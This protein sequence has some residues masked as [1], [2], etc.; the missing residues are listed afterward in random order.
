MTA[1]FLEAHSFRNERKNLIFHGGQEEAAVWYLTV[2]WML[3]PRVIHLTQRVFCKRRSCLKH[4]RIPNAKK[5]ISSQVKADVSGIDG[6]GG[7]CR[8]HLSMIMCPENGVFKG[9]AYHSLT[10]YDWL[11]LMRVRILTTSASLNQL[12]MKHRSLIAR[13]CV[14]VR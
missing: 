11:L 1:L 7:L 5:H 12:A 4:R 14:R 6:P 2:H 9:L 8:R 3:L 10:S 13:R